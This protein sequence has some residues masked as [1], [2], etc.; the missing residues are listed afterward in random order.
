MPQASGPFQKP[1]LLSPKESQ[2]DLQEARQPEKPSGALP[3]TGQAHQAKAKLEA[4]RKEL[5]T[6]YL[7]SHVSCV[8]HEL[9]HRK[10][11]SAAVPVTAVDVIL[12]A[13]CVEQP[14]THQQVFTLGCGCSLS[15]CDAIFLMPHQQQKPATLALML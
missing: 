2:E 11:W 15:P 5:G 6:H 7:P 10:Y 12:A 14:L 13:C 4:I 3:G 8:M 9:L 1:R